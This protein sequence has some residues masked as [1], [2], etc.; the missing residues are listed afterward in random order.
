METSS[1]SRQSPLADPFRVGEW[2]VYAS[3]NQLR[4]NS[5]T[6]KLEPRTMQVLLYL[7]E[8][9]G[10]TVT[11]EQLE[12]GVWKDRVVGYDSLNITISKLRRALED[13]PKDPHFIETIPKVGYRLISEIGHAAESPVVGDTAPL[14]EPN[15]GASASP[16]AESQRHA[17]LLS[18][19]ALLLLMAVIATAA[20]LWSR[21]SSDGELRVD[22]ARPMASSG[23]PSIAIL[24]FDNL[25]GDP[26][27]EYFSDGITDDLITDLS[28]I[29]G[30]TVIARDSAF[31]FK[32]E[33]TAVQEVARRLGVRY[34]LKGSVRK[35]GDR[36]RI[37]A[38]LVDADAGVQLWADRYDGPLSDVFTLQDDVTGR[39][40]TALKVR[41]TPEEKMSA[42]FHGTMN[43]DAYDAFLRG[44]SLASRMTPQ[45]AATAI[46]FFKQ[47]IARDSEYGR[48]YAMLANTH[49]SYAIN[50]RFNS[51]LDRSTGP[52]APG[53]YSNYLVAWNYLRQALLQ[54]SPEAYA[55]N[56]RMLQRQR[57][58]DQ[59]LRDA[60]RAV[61]LAPNSPSALEA[62]IETQIFAG[63]ENEALEWIEHSIRLD[64]SRPG[65]E[66]FLAGLAYYGLRRFEESLSSVRRARIHN[67]QQ[68]RYAALMAAALVEVGRRDESRVALQEYLSAWETLSDL[69]EIMLEWPFRK[70]DT[71][72]RF[73]GSLIE[74]GMPAVRKAYFAVDTSQ[75]LSSEEITAALASKT[76]VGIDRGH[77]GGVKFQVTWSEV[78]QL[79]EQGYVNYFRDGG[80]TRVA[81]DL[82]CA[83]W[84]DWGDYCV[85]VF[86]N[87][88]GDRQHLDEYVFFTLAG[89]FTFSAFE[90]TTGTQQ[91]IRSLRAE[92]R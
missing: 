59:A 28:K 1:A 70:P 32:G 47:A 37:N 62:L 44:L 86:K 61:E 60:I 54:P 74:A 81:Q 75:R 48:A 17:M 72:R 22:V 4:R 66:L 43:I 56:A 23:K 63:H 33:S 15:A 29:S 24:P 49:W 83:P 9:A 45:D 19:S 92:N 87:P 31:A 57:R 78:M 8:R 6:V 20:W 53:G 30:L 5:R 42:E 68:A 21:D 52:W 35:S 65:E 76:M 84:R 10:H 69:N 14:P 36:V 25:G 38:Q 18:I 7:A 73:A 51:L 40:V 90:P 80:T 77:P 16:K 82:L 13:D 89:T 50:R 41:L 3:A 85:A 34:V 88:G 27:Q 55:L 64:P 26:E 91:S 58:F 79:A 71:A 12:Q 46:S 2:L 11:R 39:I 67:P